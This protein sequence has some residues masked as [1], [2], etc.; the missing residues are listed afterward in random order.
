[1]KKSKSKYIVLFYLLAGIQL[2]SAASDSSQETPYPSIEIPVFQGGYD[3]SKT[4]N[5]AQD[6]KAIIYSVR[7]KYPA[8]E[9]IEFYDSFFNGRGW[10]ASF[11]ICQRHWA[12]PTNDSNNAQGLARQMYASWMHPEL[13][14]NVVLWLTY[15]SINSREQNE[16]IVEARLQSRTRK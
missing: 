10:I 3:V 16:V 6:T 14:L 7:L 11:E 15:E 8:A 12:G 5:A 13:D 2:T 4:F 1:M 9:I